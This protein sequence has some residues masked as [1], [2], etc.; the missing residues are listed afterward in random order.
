MKYY[1]EYVHPFMTIKELDDEKFTIKKRNGWYHVYLDA[2]ERTYF[3]IDCIYDTIQDC[4][5]WLRTYSK[6]VLMPDGSQKY[7]DE[8]FLEDSN[9]A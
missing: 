8:F 4:F 7:V 9:R 2:S 1:L 3:T 6:P 5:K